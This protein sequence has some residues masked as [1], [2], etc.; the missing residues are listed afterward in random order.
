MDEA[1]HK[2]K[3]IGICAFDVKEQKGRGE[4]L[5]IVH[6]SK[7]VLK[8]VLVANLLAPQRSRLKFN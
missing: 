4:H 8:S 6:K 1:R 2:C 5:F 3:I 7:Y